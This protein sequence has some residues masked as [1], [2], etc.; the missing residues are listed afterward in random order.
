MSTKFYLPFLLRLLL[1]Q[2]SSLIQGQQPYL[3]NY[4]LDCYDESHVNITRG[5]ACNGVK[6]SCQSY[7]T[8]RSLPPYNTPLSIA[9]LL[10][11]KA[12]VITNF[13]EL[14]SD[15]ATIP[16][17]DMVVVPVKCSCSSSKIYAHTARYTILNDNEDYYTIANETYQGLST[18]RA[19]MQ[20]NPIDS[21]NLGV[22]DDLKVPLLCACPTRKQVRK[23]VKFLLNYLADWDD[24]THTIAE[25]FDLDE[26]SVLDANELKEDDLIYPFTPILVPLRTTPTK[27]EQTVTSP[28]PLSPPQTPVNIFVD[29]A[30]S[31]KKW[32]FVGVGTGVGL[33][34]LMIL[35][36]SLF[37][38]YKKSKSESRRV[39]SAETARL[40]DCSPESQRY[41]SAAESLTIYKFE[42]LQ[43]ATGNFSEENRIKGSVYKGS[44]QG[45]DAAIKVMNGDVS[46]E[47]NILKKINHS[48]IIRLSGFCVHDGNT[49]LVYEC[50]QNGSLDNW[51][52]SNQYWKSITLNWKQR[53]QIAYDMANALNYLHK[54]TI[55]PYIHKNLNT[56]NILLDSNF[57]AKIANFGLARSIHSHDHGGQLQLTRHVVGTHG[58][59]APEYIENGVITT[60]LDVFAFGVVLLELLSGREAVT[61]DRNSGE[62][63]LYASISRV[64]EGENMREKLRGFIDPCLRNE[65][66]LELAFSIAQLAKHCVA[67]DLNARPS[68]DEVFTSLSKVLSSLSDWDPSDEINCSKSPSNGRQMVY[69]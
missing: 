61:E 7:L 38:F 2:F 30:P 26:R 18:C 67:Q 15:V 63:L 20:A 29:S 56:S 35:L 54:Y 68:M 58:Y 24:D 47:I 3:N 17:N 40:A 39:S 5:F 50:A 42:D 11:V 59:L 19:M 36:T 53:V 32:V 8:F 6:P 33:L 65:Y 28:P 9:Y 43:L 16:T 62:E 46:I 52:Y 60:K 69:H 4:Q 51:L 48:N 37:C 31:S 12:A 34:L 14:S 49:F 23:G 25:L 57:R 22:G 64:L 27:I 55:P 1:L 44:F 21:R 66:P 45:D 13:N 41:Q 10:A